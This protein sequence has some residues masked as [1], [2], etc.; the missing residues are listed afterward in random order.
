MQ[1]DGLISVDYNPRTCVALFIFDPSARYELGDVLGHVEDLTDG[2]TR[3]V[4]VF[5]GDYLARD[6]RKRGGRV[7][8]RLW[9]NVANKAGISL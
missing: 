8:S 7:V 9:V 6:M 5:E 2:R 3:R 4:L 1:F